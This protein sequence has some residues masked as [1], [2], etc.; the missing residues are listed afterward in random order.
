MMR[1]MW[2]WIGFS[3]IGVAH[4]RPPRHG[5]KSTS[6]FFRNVRF[7]LSGIVASSV[8][9]LKLIPFFGLGLSALSFVA[10]V[11]LAVD[12]ILFGVPFAGTARSSRS[13]C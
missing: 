7:A 3:S 10:I 9:P 12:W 2:S 4:E 8:A 11:V 1:T 13:S 6:T 5:G